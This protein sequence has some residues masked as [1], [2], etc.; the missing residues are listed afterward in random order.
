[1]KLLILSFCLLCYLG[2]SAQQYETVVFNYEKSYFGENAPL[3]AEKYFMLSG[4]VN[5]GVPMV[6]VQ[7]FSGQ[8]QKN[9]A[10]L[11]RTY[12]KRGMENKGAVSYSIPINYK[13]R[14]NSEYDLLLQYFRPTTAQERDTLRYKLN[15]VLEAYLEQNIQSKKR[16]LRLM[17]TPSQILKEMNSVVIDGMQLY[18][19]RIRFEFEGFSDLIADQLKDLQQ[20]RGKGVNRG[21][22]LTKLL[23]QM[24]GELE[25]YF[26]NELYVLLDDRFIEDYPTEKTRAVLAL[27]AGYAGIP[28]TYDSNNFNYGAAPY[29]GLSFPLGKK[30]FSPFWHR[31]ALSVGAFLVQPE[32]RNGVRAEG[33]I[34]G[35][36]LY[37]ALSY[38]PWRFLR[39]HAGA[40]VLENPDNGVVQ[41]LN[42]Q[43]N[44]R[45]FV[46]V[47]VEFS[48]WLDLAE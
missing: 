40:T 11:Y 17:R 48:L 35:V 30:N 20:L 8:G 44:V 22:S 16:G 19:H 37:G 23:R 45:P 27:N 21:A 9:R 12:W 39:V 31:T 13:L 7:V 41:G 36:P 38:R 2:V 18:R 14:Q 29:L 32:D 24:Q 5:K 6:E 46:G 43:L 15:E 42:Q 28:F 4:P 25:P 10:P 26:A 47:S 1:M 34:S 33:P 3:P